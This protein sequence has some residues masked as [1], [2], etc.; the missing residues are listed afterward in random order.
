MCVSLVFIFYDLQ[1]C[2]TGRMFTSSEAG[3]NIFEGAQFQQTTSDSQ[4]L[5]NPRS[6]D[7]SIH[8]L[9]PPLIIRI[10]M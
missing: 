9:A 4:K 10:F 8:K 5:K 7:P 1:A 3:H 2:L 6:H